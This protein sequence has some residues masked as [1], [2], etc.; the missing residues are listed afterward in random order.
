MSL[1]IVKWTRSIS[2]LLAILTIVLCDAIEKIDVLVLKKEKLASL[3]T[4]IF[5][6]SSDTRITG[7][8]LSN[9]SLTRVTHDIDIILF[10]FSRFS[11]RFH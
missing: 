1:L 4:I 9:S 11:C 7:T 6:I 5:G 10:T 2:L 3:T 8:R